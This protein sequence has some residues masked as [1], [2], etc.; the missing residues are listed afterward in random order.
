MTLSSD[1]LRDEPGEAHHQYVDT[2]GERSGST[3][4]IAAPTVRRH[5]L[6]RAVIA[7]AL[8][9][10]GTFVGL[11]PAEAHDR[12]TSAVPAPEASTNGAPSQI[13]MH[14]TRP[15]ISDGRTKVEVVAPS[16]RDISTG[17][18]ASNG[19]GVGQRLAD[20]RET[21]WYRVRFSVVLVDGQVT[22]GAYRFRV[23]SVGPSAPGHGGWF[24]LLGGAGVGYFVLRTLRHAR[25]SSELRSVPVVESSR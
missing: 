7:L 19:L 13:Q 6:A 17:A 22:V 4:S 21:G 12:L 14:F 2:S 24:M 10:L 25:H 8:V 3:A 20:S 9:S 15:T 11:S 16:G 18:P 1:P 5:V 23:A